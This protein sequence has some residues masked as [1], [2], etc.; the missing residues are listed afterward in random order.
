MQV[1]ILDGDEVRQWLTPDCDF[2]E[3]GRRK[4]AERVYRAAK[5]LPDAIVAVVAHPPG[6]VDCLIWVDGPNR[7]PLWEGTAYVPPENPDITVRTW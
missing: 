2:S 4:H 3:E 1:Q 6:P 7:K 5:M